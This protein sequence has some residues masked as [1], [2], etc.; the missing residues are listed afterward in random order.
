MSTQNKDGE[1]D[2]D[3][4]WKANVRTVVGCM[5]VWFLASY[6]CGILFADALNAFRIGGFPLGFWFSQQGAIVV[7]LILI[8]FYAWRLNKL[9]RDFDVDER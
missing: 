9:D 2:A 5:I 8:A 6:G 1:T 4:Y 3:R 7:F